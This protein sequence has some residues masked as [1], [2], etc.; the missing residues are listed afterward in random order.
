VGTFYNPNWIRSHLFPLAH[1]ANVREVRVVCSQPGQA[2]RGLVYDVPPAWLRGLMGRSISKILWFFV[3][4]CRRRPDAAMGY[5]IMPNG[6]LCLMA[7]GLLGCRSIYQMT[8]GP[9][10]F[11]G[12]G[13]GSENPLLHMQGRPSRVLENWMFGMGRLLDMIVVR[14]NGAREFLHDRRICGSAPI[15]TGSVDVE[16]FCPGAEPKCYDIACVSRLMP[17]KGLDLFLEVIALLKKSGR[18][19]RAA[20][21]GDG[22][23][24]DSL[25]DQA[26]Q[27]GI[28]ANVAFLGQTDDV[29]SIL[30]KARL[31]MLISASEGLSIAM[32][33]AMSAGLPV[34]VSDV[35]ELRDAIDGGRA[36]ILLSDR[37]PACMAEVVSGLLADPVRLEAMGAAARQVAVERYSLQAVAARWAAVL[38]GGERSNGSPESPAGPDPS[39]LHAAGAS[40]MLAGHELQGRRQDQS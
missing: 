18:E 30:A 34:L 31:F 1:A 32:L 23:M 29:P 38:N 7:S 14:G 15:V 12:G 25:L 10:Q 36:G 5:H 39:A 3:V 27:L 16:R 21:V 26:R 11:I 17:F 37:R 6:L 9:V 4:A 24:R 35:G 33:E 28:E 2:Y 20:V 19:I 22:V 13:W 40:G 8:G